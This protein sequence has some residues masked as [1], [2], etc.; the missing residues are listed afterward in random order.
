MAT[1]AAEQADAQGAEQREDAEPEDRVDTDEACPGGA[2]KRAVGDRVRDEGRA[3]QDDEEA[4]EAGDDGDDR[5]DRPGVD[6]EA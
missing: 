4:D 6:H 5:G 2:G 1:A 3:A